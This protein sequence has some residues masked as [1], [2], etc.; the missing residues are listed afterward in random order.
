MGALT[1]NLGGISAGLIFL[2][3]AG[4]HPWLVRAASP[5][6]PESLYDLMAACGF[7]LL[8]WK[9]RD[10]L[11]A[12]RWIA[13]GMAF[14][15][16]YLARPEG[17]LVGFL[18]GVIAFVGIRRTSPRA[19]AGLVLFVVCLLLVAL[20]YLLFLKR[21]TGG[22]TVTGKTTEMFFVGQAV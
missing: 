2:V 15:L 5:I 3:L 18:A 22:W 6:Q 11:R 9:T 21:E 7:T 1:L 16:A 4:L 20:P 19:F 14:G 12:G 13:A 8:L 17:I 10:G